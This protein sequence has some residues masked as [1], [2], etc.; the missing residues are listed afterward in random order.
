[1]ERS[2]VILEFALL[3]IYAV[4]T[5]MAQIV[6]AAKHDNSNSNSKKSDSGSATSGSDNGKEHKTSDNP[7]ISNTALSNSGTTSTTTPTTPVDN[8]K[9]KPIGPIG[10]AR[11]KIFVIELNLYIL[12]TRHGRIFANLRQ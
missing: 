8:K 7:T 3:V 12:Y 10:N 1:M 4:I 2:L 5:T 11:C 6:I 9:G